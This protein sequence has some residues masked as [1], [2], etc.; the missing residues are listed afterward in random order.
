MLGEVSK[1]MCYAA[2]KAR[3]TFQLT[4]AGVGDLQGDKAVEL[5]KLHETPQKLIDPEWEF[6]M[7]LV[8]SLC[9][10]KSE[11]RLV[12]KMLQYFPAPGKL[13]DID[14]ALRETALI[15]Q[16]Y[17]YKLASKQAQVKHA[18]I[19]K[20]LGRL[21]DGRSPDFAAWGP[22]DVNLAR[23]MAK[24]PLFVTCPKKDAKGKITTIVGRVALNEMYTFAKEKPLDDLT[25]EY[26]QKFQAF[27]WLFEEVLRKEVA[28]FVRQFRQA[29]GSKATGSA[30]GSASSKAS[31]SKG[32]S[33]KK[34]KA[35]AE[36][37]GMFA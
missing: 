23:V 24:L 17:V 14:S 10:P 31:A 5:M 13:I 11:G 7:F 30:S 19:V 25:A 27:D 18:M 15:N 2:E 20:C 9:G 34:D 6:E 32:A 16:L 12:T 1:D 36:A 33:T 21:L 22:D 8:S 3:A 37:L 4:A 26:V 28:E 35:V 29:Q